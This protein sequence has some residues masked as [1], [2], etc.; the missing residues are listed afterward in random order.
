MR[1]GRIAARV[2][3]L[4]RL[5]EVG[6]SASSCNSLSLS[7]ILGCCKVSEL[8]QQPAG[9]APGKLWKLDKLGAPRQ[10]LGEVL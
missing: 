7:R 10:L 9:A 4:S 5:T 8:D 1:A 3:F 6:K 2:V